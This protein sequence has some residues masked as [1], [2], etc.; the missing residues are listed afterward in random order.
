MWKTL[1][2]F[3]EWGQMLRPSKEGRPNGPPGLGLGPKDCLTEGQ[4]NW[5]S[6]P[7]H[8]GL[9][10]TG[11]QSALPPQ[12]HHLLQPLWEVRLHPRLG[13]A[14]WQSTLST[15]DPGGSILSAQNQ[16]INKEQT[17][18][19]FGRQ[20]TIFRTLNCLFYKRYLKLFYFMGMGVL[21]ACMSGLHVHVWCLQRPEEGI[22]Y[23]ELSYRW[24]QATIWELEI[25]LGFSGRA[26]SALNWWT[27]LSTWKSEAGEWPRVQI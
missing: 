9:K 13:V 15:S 12:Q 3:S 5:K 24:L 2:S 17:L 22:E 14:Q 26:A 1:H 21:L 18:I 4:T 11:F 27:Y 20:L 19:L 23:P 10:M 16:Y 8:T 7:S 6:M 25:E